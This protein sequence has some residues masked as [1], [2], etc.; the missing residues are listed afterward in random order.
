MIL[1]I[2]K[3]EIRMFQLMNKKTKNYFLPIHGIYV[4]QVAAYGIGNTGCFAV[5]GVTGTSTQDKQTGDTLS[6]F[7]RSFAVI[8]DIGINDIL[9]TQTFGLLT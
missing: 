3:L 2:M 8:V 6:S 4:R 9:E 5:Y 7:F 1:V